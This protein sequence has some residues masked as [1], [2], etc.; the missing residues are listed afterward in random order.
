MDGA[1]LDNFLWTPTEVE[2]VVFVAAVVVEDGFFIRVVSDITRN[3]FAKYNLT[4]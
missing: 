3:N 2:D 1:W 4:P